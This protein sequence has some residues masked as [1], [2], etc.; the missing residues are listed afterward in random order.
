MAST[1]SN[2]KPGS[3]FL[4]AA[5]QFPA[6]IVN[7]RAD[8]DRQLESIIKTLRSTKKCYPGV[9]LVIFPE[10]SLQG[11]NTEKWLTEDFL[12]DVPGP[13]TGVMA[14]ACKEL[15]VYGVFS[16]IERNPNDDK[17]NPFD[18]A[19]II[20][21]N[22]EIILHYRKLFPWTPIEPWHP[23]DKGVPVCDGP[24]GSKLAVAICHDGMIP[25]L[26]R[27]AAY[28]GA[29]VLVRISGYSTQVNDQWEL[30]NRANAW[31]N[32]MYTISVNLAGYDG[33]FYYFGEGQIC[34]YDGTTL[35]QGSRSPWE[36]VTGT[37]TPAEADDARRTWGLENNIYNLGH[38]GYVDV[39]G[40]DKL[41]PFTWVDDLSAGKYRLPWHD[42]VQVTDGTSYGYPAAG[43]RFGRG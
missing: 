38:R 13:E 22:G 3:G 9:E 28:K 11:L 35:V 42:Q 5:I 23:G 1:G 7:S 19:I 4:A 2:T 12:C 31:N 26:A 32:L 15:G 29:N 40:G 37:I 18:T 27:E 20:D 33:D 43:G 21:P 25:E 14:E 41:N 24:G 8:I 17:E 16:V 39:P 6:P 34:N 10:Y 30:T 36:I